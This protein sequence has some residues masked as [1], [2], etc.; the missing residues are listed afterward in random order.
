VTANGGPGTLTYDWALPD[1]RT[2]DA[3][4]VQVTGGQERVLLDLSFQLTGPPSVTG[5]PVLELRAPETVH[6]EGPP[7]ALRC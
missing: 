5:R 2:T 6:R 7:V 3:S 4:S 1:G